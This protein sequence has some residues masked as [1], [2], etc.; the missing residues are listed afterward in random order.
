[1]PRR[2]LLR[3]IATAAVRDLFVTLVL[4]RLCARSYFTSVLAELSALHGA[5]WLRVGNP[6]DAWPPHWP[7]SAPVKIPTELAGSLRFKLESQGTVE[8]PFFFEAQGT[9]WA[10]YHENV[11]A[12]LNTS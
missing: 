3:K 12:K 5:S 1:M 8:P 10:T 4:W 2:R 7:G 6:Y 9:I 11:L